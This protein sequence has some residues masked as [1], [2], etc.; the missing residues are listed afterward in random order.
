MASRARIRAALQKATLSLASFG[1]CLVLI[2]IGYR[3]L[4]PFPYFDPAEI[5]QTEH[6]NLSQF[7]PVLGWKGVPSASLVMT[8]MNS[9][10]R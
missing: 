3:F 1:A 2:E 8:T 9:Q 10:V 6:G 7:D 5:N 4:D